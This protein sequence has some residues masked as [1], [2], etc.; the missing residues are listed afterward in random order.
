MNLNGKLR[1][2]TGGAKRGAKQKYGGAMAHPGP[3]RI[4]TVPDKLCGIVVGHIEGVKWFCFSAF[5]RILCSC[6]KQ[7]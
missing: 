1:K 7:K 5:S 3:L 4:A 2:T 6:W